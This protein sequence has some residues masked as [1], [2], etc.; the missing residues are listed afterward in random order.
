MHSV[1]RVFTKVC[2]YYYILFNKGV[3]EH[4]TVQAALD[5]Y[6]QLKITIPEKWAHS[7]KSQHAGL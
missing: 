4:D 1:R 6:N 7:T 3:C 5:S 2:H